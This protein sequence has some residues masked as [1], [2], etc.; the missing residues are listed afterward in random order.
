MC[1]IF[2][3]VNNSPSVDDYQVIVATNRDEFFMRPTKPAALWSNG[4][5]ISGRDLEAGREGGTWFGVSTHGKIAAL[6][7]ITEKSVNADKAGRGHLVSDYL[8]SD[9]DPVTYAD[10][11]ALEADQFNGFN[12]LL[13]K[14]RESQWSAQYCSNRVADQSQPLVIPNDGI[15]ACSNTP[16]FEPLSKTTNGRTRFAEVVRSAM[17]S[18]HDELKQALLGLLNDK[19]S[20]LP[21]ARESL[22]PDLFPNLSSIFVDLAER[23]GY[24]TRTQTIVLIDG[25]VRGNSVREL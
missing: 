23:G 19:S 11:I 22:R 8:S 25:M 7:N 2:L 16:F 3:Y 15:L 5:C 9:I 10:R 21:D 4:H 1:I 24:G 18:R 12:L 20:N 17:T 14:K 13:L 6:Q